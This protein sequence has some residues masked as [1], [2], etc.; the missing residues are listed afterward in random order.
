[1]GSQRNLGVVLILCSQTWLRIVDMTSANRIENVCPE[2]GAKSL[3]KT[4]QTMQVG[5]NEFNPLPGLWGWL[6]G[7]SM[8]VVACSECGLIRLYASKDTR[9][10]LPQS[11]K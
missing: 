10:K 2:C 11:R 5:G 7:T 8:S 6:T 3:Y 9:K 1:E 4:R